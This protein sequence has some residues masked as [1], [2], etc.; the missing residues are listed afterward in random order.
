MRAATPA[1]WPARTASMGAALRNSP[2]T[3]GA[4]GH[5]GLLADLHGGVDHLLL[6]LGL[7]GEDVRHRGRLQGLRV[8]RLDAEQFAEHAPALDRLRVVD[9]VMS[10]AGLRDGLVEEAGRL[11]RAHQRGDGHAAGGLAEDGDVGGVAA[12]AGD[13]VAH[14]AQGGDLVAH[15]EVGLFQRGQVKESER[16]ESVVDGDDDDI[17]ALGE[18]RAVVEASSLPGADG[19]GAAV[20]P[21]HDRTGGVVCGGRPDV[22]EEAV[23]GLLLR[24]AAHQGIERLVGNLGGDWAEGLAVEHVVPAGMRSGDAEAQIADRRGGVGDASVDAEVVFG[25]AVDSA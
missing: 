15:A 25:C 6:E 7:G 14:P 23:L 8:V 4:E 19:E 22:E 17:A 13:V 9:A 16:A 21:D 20:D 1:A 11:G 18:H 12:E 5:F 24:G 10:G 3:I 2:S